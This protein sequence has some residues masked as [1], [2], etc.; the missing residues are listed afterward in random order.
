MLSRFKSGLAITVCAAAVGFPALANTPTINTY[1]SWDRSSA[2]QSFGCP[3]TTTMGQV[4]TVPSGMHH[5]NKFTFW[6]K[7]FNYVSGSSMVVRA[8]VYKWD[9]VNSKP[10]GLSLFDSAPRT[11]SFGDTSFHPEPFNHN[12]PVIPGVQYVM[13]VSID[14]EYVDCKNN[15]QLSSGILGNDAYPGGAFVY[16]TD[17]G[18][19]LQ[20]TAVSWEHLGPD[21]YDLAFKA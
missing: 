3:E 19:D 12:V 6:W 18:D 4:I 14:W 11:I 21:S 8:H 16:S 13:F 2:V 10:H 5:L 17:G 9:A 7:D 1:N 15:Y 20:W